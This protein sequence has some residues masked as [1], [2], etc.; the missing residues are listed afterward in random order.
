VALDSGSPRRSRRGQCD[1][2]RVAAQSHE[3]WMA[4]NPGQGASPIR[5]ADR[6]LP[7][8]PGTATSEHLI[9]LYIGHV[10]EGEGSMRTAN[11]CGALITT[12]ALAGFVEVA[13]ADTLYRWYKRDANNEEFRRTKAEC[14]MGQMEVEHPNSSTNPDLEWGTTTYGLCMRA[15]GWVPVRWASIDA[16]PR[17]DGPPVSRPGNGF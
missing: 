7:P 16:H 9:G 4:S 14:L 8:A 1:G 5:R 17:R 6:R 11:I 13:A 15:N 10:S 2:E 3:R 12:A